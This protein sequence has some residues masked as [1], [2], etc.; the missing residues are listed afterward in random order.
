VG[1]ALPFAI[2]AQ[3]Q[4]PL[5]HIRAFGEGVVSVRPDVARINISV[6]TQ[7]ATAE[8]AAAE[9]AT[10]A[11]AVNDAL[12]G[13]FRG[14]EIRTLSYTLSPNYRSQAPGQPS[15]IAGYTATNTIE[16]TT[17]DLAVIGQIID[18]AIGAGAA[19]VDGLR[20][21]LKDEEPAR[22]QALRLAGQKAR[23]KADAIAL[24]VGVTLGR[25][26]AAEEGVSY[27]PVE[28][29][30]RAATAAPTPIEPGLL[31]VHAT[32]T[33]QMEIVP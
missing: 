4:G 13:K 27:R 2:L 1:I 28:L 6:I 11:T 24:G 21:T 26:I 5:R 7:G 10:V 17:G 19:R 16:I 30:T 32:I 33:L 18:T 12:T 9:N 20:L 15:V 22:S 25:V 23:A 3:A 31:Q 8:Q 14:A 29:D